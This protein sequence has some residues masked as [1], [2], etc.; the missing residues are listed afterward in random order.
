MRKHFFCSLLLVA[1][2]SA[3]VLASHCNL[4]GSTRQGTLEPCDVPA[5]EAGS[6]SGAASGEHNFDFAATAGTNYTFT[7]CS[8]G[9]TASYDTGLS[10]WEGSTQRAC[11]D[12]SCGLRSQLTWQAPTTGNFVIRIGGFGGQTGSYTMSY[13]ADIPCSTGGPAVPSAS[14]WSLIAAAAAVMFVLAGK[15]SRNS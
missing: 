14:V 5:T 7:F 2:V 15:A 3:P 8:G 9:G 13:L 10:I 4:P 11:N 6:T 12:D 1:L